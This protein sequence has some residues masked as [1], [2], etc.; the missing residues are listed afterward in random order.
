MG[1]CGE[2]KCRQDEDCLERKIEIV[3]FG[4][5]KTCRQACTSKVSNRDLFFNANISSLALRP[6][7]Q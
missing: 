2:L 3:R 4:A 1:G 5:A 7:D 6:V